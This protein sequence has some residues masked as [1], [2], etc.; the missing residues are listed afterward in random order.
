MSE[1]IYEQMSKRKVPPI[2]DD[3]PSVYVEALMR[4]EQKTAEK[5]ERIEECRANEIELR[6]EL[7][8]V[9]DNPEDFGHD[10]FV[11]RVIEITGVFCSDPLF[12][13]RTDQNEK[14]SVRFSDFAEGDVIMD[15]QSTTRVIAIQ[16]TSNDDGQKLI[17]FEVNINDFRDRARRENEV[18]VPGR[19]ED[20]VV[21]YEAQLVSS[22]LEYHR[23]FLQLNTD[24]LREFEQ[25][26]DQYSGM[27]AD[28]CGLFQE[29]EMQK[30]ITQY[31]SQMEGDSLRQSGFT[32]RGNVVRAADG[33][34]L[35]VSSVEGPRVNT[36]NSAVKWSPW[37]QKL[38]YVVLGILAVAMVVNLGHSVFLS[39]ITACFFL[40]WYI[41]RNELDRLIS[42]LFLTVGF[43]ISLAFNILWVIRVSGSVWSGSMVLSEGTLSFFDKFTVVMTYLLCVVELLAVCLSVYLLKDGI[44]LRPE[45]RNLISDFKIKL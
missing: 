24:R 27:K 22:K 32:Q 35:R 7:R 9:E 16:A 29:S 10:K 2:M 31:S 43:G 33:S 34:G 18:S 41:Q 5:T 1:E 30:A 28:L 44:T 3:F 40:T 4:L 15:I 14:A 45:D 25:Y 6:K 19:D 42:P 23:G 37:L 38:F 39:I 20:V 17:A 12:D 13:I 26:R 21:I 36:I 8:S 11:I